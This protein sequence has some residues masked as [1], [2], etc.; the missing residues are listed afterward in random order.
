MCYFAGD[1]AEARIHCERALDACDPE[2][3]RETRE[4]FGDDTGAIA[5]SCLAATMWQLGEV[6]R[7]REVIDQANRRATELGHAPSMAH[8]LFFKS[9]LETLRGD[10]A[11]ALGSAETLEGLSQKQGMVFWRIVAEC[12]AGWPRGRLRDAATGA[13][14]LRRALAAAA[15][16]GGLGDAWFYTV[17]LA[18]LEAETL[19]ADG[20][21]KRID[22]ALTRASRV[23]RRCNLAFPYRLRGELLLKRDPANPGAAEEAFQSAIAIAKEQAARSWG[24]RAA[25][26]LAK[27][28]QSTGRPV[29]AHA[30]L[31]PAL[32]GFSPTPEMPEIA[33]AQTL[34]AAL[35]ESEEVKAGAA[36]RRR[37]THLRVAY[38]HALIATRGYGAPETTEAFTAAR[39]STHG[40]SA[41]PERL[42]ADYGLWVGSYC[43][44]S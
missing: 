29:D 31:G 16:Q 23:G 24:L 9:Y 20:A 41:A 15:D 13:E 22:E 32:E 14:D 37:M 2:R 27:L 38:G 18:D 3:D 10:A 43:G 6:E 21:L 17:L 36:Q 1:F 26:S 8:P 19:G 39:E 33:E 28:Y 4:R 34:L 35:A 12:L 44:E 5:I 25:L 7:A 30:V 11:A 40:D 42:A